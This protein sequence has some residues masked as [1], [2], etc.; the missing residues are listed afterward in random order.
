MG[1][2]GSLFHVATEDERHDRGQRA[3]GEGDAPSPVAQ[4][5]LAQ[6]FLEH[7]QHRQREQMTHD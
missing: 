3:D 7:Q 2:G 5:G 1:E 4:F 6:E